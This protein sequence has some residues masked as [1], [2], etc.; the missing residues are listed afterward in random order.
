[1]SS[2][3]EHQ[4][5]SEQVLQGETAMY[6]PSC[7]KQT[8]DNSIYCLHC[9]KPTST[10]TSTQEIIEWENKDFNLTWTEGTTGWVSAEHY[11]EPAARLYYW[12][13]YQSIL[14]PDCRN[15]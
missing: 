2:S 12:Q 9:G 5:A 7:G 1:M 4:D 14:C 15:C 10:A 13:N 8:P 6:C 11:T 3:V